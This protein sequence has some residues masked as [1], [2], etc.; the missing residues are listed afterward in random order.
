MNTQNKT[1]KNSKTS[2]RRDE[3]HETERKMEK[4][5]LTHQNRDQPRLMIPHDG[6]FLS[7]LK[8]A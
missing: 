2:R 1:N 5:H 3:Q 4:K 7:S 8:L 6:F